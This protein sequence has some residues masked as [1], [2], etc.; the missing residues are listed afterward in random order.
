MKKSVILCLLS[1]VL[2]GCKSQT[3]DLMHKGTIAAVPDLEISQSF[4]LWG[5]LQSS[6]ID[7]GRVCKG[8]D[9]VARIQTV[10]TIMDTLES[11][12][13]FYLYTP[14]T[15]RVYCIRKSLEADR[16]RRA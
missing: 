10:T 11:W 5:I 15:V 2:S 4:L 1:V 8:H 3:V 12:L 7:A 13:S 9:K 6:S 16:P 14:R